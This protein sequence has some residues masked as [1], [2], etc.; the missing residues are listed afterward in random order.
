M[1]RLS[2]DAELSDYIVVLD[3]PVTSMDMNRRYQ[4]IR[5]ISQLSTKCK[6]LIVL[7]HDLFFLRDLRQEL[8]GIKP[9]PIETVTLKITR[10]QNDDSTFADC[11]IE[12]KC[13]SDYYRHFQMVEE[14]VDGGSSTNSRDVAKAIRPLI[15]GYLHRRF[16]CHIPKKMMLGKIIADYI[17]PATTGA[18]A[19][20][21]PRVDELQ[22]LNEYASRFHHD[23]NRDADH[24]TVTD[25]ELKT[26]ADR[27][28]TLIYGGS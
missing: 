19:H 18:L 20:L 25:A 27:T 7:S 3:D 15:E 16:P 13:R 11:D 1:A 5:Q 4:T 28:L 9:T 23:T 22:A 8:L 26:F 6:Q 10:V 2:C 14:F 17:K 24:A 12:S 21:T